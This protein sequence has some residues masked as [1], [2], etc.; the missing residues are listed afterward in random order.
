MNFYSMKLIGKICR[1]SVNTF[2]R[3]TRVS[4]ME[5]LTAIFYNMREFITRSASS[6]VMRTLPSVFSVKQCKTSPTSGVAK[7]ELECNRSVGCFKNVSV[8]DDCSACICA[9]HNARTRSDF[10]K[11]SCGIA[12]LPCR[13]CGGGFVCCL[14]VKLHCV[15]PD[16]E[17]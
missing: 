1:H 13:G 10:G 8:G 2:I 3:Y 12:E 14:G 7:Q 4:M 16:D 11:R 17:T 6:Y 9:I 15:K 5:L